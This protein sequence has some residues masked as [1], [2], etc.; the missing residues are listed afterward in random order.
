MREIY[1]AAAYVR[2]WLDQQVTKDRVRCVKYIWLLNGEGPFLDDNGDFDDLNED[3]TEPSE[4]STERKSDDTKTAEFSGISGTPTLKEDQRFVNTNETTFNE[5][6][7][8]WNSTR[9]RGYSRGYSSGMPKLVWT[10]SEHNQAASRRAEPSEVKSES[11]STES[12]FTTICG[13]QECG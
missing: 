13:F 10:P 2:I 12:L 7:S 3:H 11:P 4:P 5:E 9:R 1:D 8:T 6:S